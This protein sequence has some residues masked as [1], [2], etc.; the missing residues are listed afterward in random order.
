MQPLFIIPSAANKT[1]PYYPY[2]AWSSLPLA[3]PLMIEPTSVYGS[4]SGILAITSFTWWWSGDEQA[5]IIDVACVSY[6]LSYPAAISCGVNDLPIVVATTSVVLS[7]TRWDNSLQFILT[8]SLS[9]S[10]II[11]AI[12]EEYLILAT[13]IIAIVAKM[14]DLLGGYRH[15]TAIFHVLSGIALFLIQNHNLVVYDDSVAVYAPE[16]LPP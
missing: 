4:M 14:V 13:T 12:N 5:R 9:G 1:P 16:L 10:L 11:L 15:G 2:N 7:T 3:I 8:T 6:F